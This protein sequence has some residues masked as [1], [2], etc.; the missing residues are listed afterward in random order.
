MQEKFPEFFKE[1]ESIIMY[2]P[3]SEVLGSIEDGV[4][5]FSYGQIVK[6]A[7]HSCPTVAGAYLTCKRALEVL[8]PE[9]LYCKRGDTSCICKEPTKWRYWSGRKCDESYHRSL[10]RGRL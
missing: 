7:G 5:C 4:I 2:D 9:K 1:V 3:L 8:Y 6:A 10:C